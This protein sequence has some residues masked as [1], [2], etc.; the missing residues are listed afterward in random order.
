MEYKQQPL[1]LDINRKQLNMFRDNSQIEADYAEIERLR[2]LCAKI[3]AEKA[4]RIKF[5]LQ[6][7][8]L[9]ENK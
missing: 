8:R 2:I 1:L 9:W 3:E 4:E 5:T 7:S 6:N